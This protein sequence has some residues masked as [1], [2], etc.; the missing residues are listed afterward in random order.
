MKPSQLTGD[1]KAEFE[2][3]VAN[4]NGGGPPKTTKEEDKIEVEESEVK[5]S[6]EDPAPEKP[7]PQVE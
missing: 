1:K 5:K 3:A 6:E 7:K 2:S 4:M